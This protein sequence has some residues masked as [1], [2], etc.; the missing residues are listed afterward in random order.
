LRIISGTEKGRKL[1]T[2]PPQDKSIRPTSD[3][4]REALFSILGKT[5]YGARILDLFAGTG[6][7]GL[8]AFSRNAGFVVFIDNNHRALELIK[9]NI[10]LCLSRPTGNCQFRVIQYD[11]T[12]GLPPLR[13]LLPPETHSGFNII[14]ADPPYGKNIS[15]SMINFINE[16][17]LLAEKGM[18]IVEERFNIALPKE[19]SHLRL[20][21]RRTYGESGF[22]LYQSS[23]PLQTTKG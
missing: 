23:C 9:K 6:A 8:E 1:F 5:I 7:M 2:P 17:S 11:L 20:I 16:S 12:K 4:A 22:W 19:L 14:F 13:H 15:L 10:G 3:R 18:L 21:D